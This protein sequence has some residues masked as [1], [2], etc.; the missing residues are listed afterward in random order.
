M[1]VNNSAISRRRFLAT[2]AKVGAVA[3]APA[4]VPGSALG[5]DG[6]VAAS[7]RITVG[8]IG[9]NARGAYVLGALLSLPDTRFVAICDV[10]ADRRKA[11]KEMADTKYGNRDCATYR[12]L[13]EL[14]A[15][16]DID[17][18]LIATGDRWH[19]LASVMAARAGK[20]VYVEK[21]CS[22]SMAESRIL[23][24]TM[25]RYGRV[26]QVGTQRRTIDSFKF[27]ADLARSGKLGKLHTLHASLAF[28]GGGPHGEQVRHD[29]LP[30]EPEPPKETLD[31]EMWLGPSPWRPYNATYAAGP[32]CS[33][34]LSYFDFNAGGGL[35][36]WASHTVDLCQWANQSDGSAPVEFEPVGTARGYAS[37]RVVHGRYANGV[38]LILARQHE[39]WAGV[40]G[41]RFDGTEGWIA[42][43]G[44]DHEQSR[45]SSPSLLAEVD[46]MIERYTAL[47]RRPMNHARDFFDCIKSRRPTVANPEAMHGAMT[48]VHAANICMWLKR[49]LVYDPV[50]EEFV[51][52]PEANRLR[53]RAMRAPW[54]A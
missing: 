26:F 30:A 51:N 21:P 22:M 47:M 17:A 45:A 16:S 36:N 33:G 52:D 43:S 18:V 27:A 32:G 31:W 6:G 10:R 24:E 50:K 37:K 15:R 42:N 46:K 23:A 12:D 14:L 8:G 5:K 9:I 54:V 35:L 44:S 25:R 53:S 28:Y 4:F 48:T 3:A 13:R 41:Q 7:E 39:S 11:V 34:W 38:K 19:A 20:D 49:D 1:K 29:W 40:S 2:A